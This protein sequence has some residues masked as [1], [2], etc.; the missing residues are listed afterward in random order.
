MFLNIQAI[1]LCIV[2]WTCAYK[3]IFRCHMVL[4]IT[5]YIMHS[6]GV[7]FLSKVG[8]IQYS[9]QDNYFYEEET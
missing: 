9:V 3:H 5:Y 1:I 2:L 7:M 4:L 8:I 6:I